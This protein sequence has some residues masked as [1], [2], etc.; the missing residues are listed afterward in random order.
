MGLDSLLYIL[1]AVYIHKKNKTMQR[2][3]HI[4]YLF[5][6]IFQSHFH[7]FKTEGIKLHYSSPLF[8]SNSWYKKV[9]FQWQRLN[10]KRKENGNVKYINSNSFIQ[11]LGV[12]LTTECNHVSQ[13]FQRGSGSISETHLFLIKANSV[14]TFALNMRTKEHQKRTVFLLSFSDRRKLFLQPF[15]AAAS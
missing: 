14:P 3:R 9:F 10:L 13:T 12:F 4:L 6:F 5:I 8:K 7:S 2:S 15:E 11:K 1:T